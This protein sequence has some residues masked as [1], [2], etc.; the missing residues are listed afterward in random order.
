MLSWF[1]RR[2]FFFFSRWGVAAVDSCGA[3]KVLRIGQEEDAYHWRISLSLSLS[4]SLLFA[5]ECVCVCVCGGSGTDRTG[6]SGMGCV[7]LDGNVHAGEEREM[8]LS[9][10]IHLGVE[11]RA[12][13]GARYVP[14]RVI[15]F[16]SFGVVCQVSTVG[17]GETVA[18]KKVL[19]DK[20]FKNR[21]LQ[22]MRLVS[23]PNV[24]A[25]KNSFFTTGP[26]DSV[27]LN[28]VLESV[29]AYGLF[30]S[31]HVFGLRRSLALG[32]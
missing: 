29:P 32:L 31:G 25:L 15:G 7:R 19:Q 30:D 21:E 27:C 28:L 14:E 22:I 16:G 23:H 24:V 1:R 26:G 8:E 12:T 9:N 17:S 18:I 6:W 2:N 4:L 5:C 11:I 13:N 20:R 3:R 10:H